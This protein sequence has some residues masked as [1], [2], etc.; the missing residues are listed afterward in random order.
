ME[1]SRVRILKL[2]VLIDYIFAEWEYKNWL[3]KNFERQLEVQEGR[4]WG[5]ES[6][7]SG[8]KV[9]KGVYVGDKGM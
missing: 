7:L 9:N 2:R 8:D 3:V 5:V 6:K 1:R 4:E